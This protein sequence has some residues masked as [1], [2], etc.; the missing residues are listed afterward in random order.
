MCMISELGE[1]I[2][3]LLGER[4]M[5]QRNLADNANISRHYLNYLIHGKRF[6]PSHEII[7]KIANTLGVSIDA[8]SLSNIEPKEFHNVRSIPLISWVQAGQWHDP[9]DTYH[10]GHADEWISSDSADPNAFALRVQGD[11]MEPEFYENDIIVVSP[12]IEPASGD[13]AVVKVNSQVT[14]KQIHIYMSKVVLKPLND[15]YQP[16]EIQREDGKKIKI[17]GKVIQ[18]IK[19][20]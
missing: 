10:P 2:L 11:S 12:A 18:K 16:E 20:Y 17:V 8:F 13:Y 4:K 15:K 6:N 14:F 9:D 5:T 1:I 7:S 19:K 3:R